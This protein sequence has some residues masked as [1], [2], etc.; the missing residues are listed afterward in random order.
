MARVFI[1]ASP[2]MDTIIVKYG[3]FPSPQRTDAP[4]VYN[5][6]VPA[7]R[8]EMTSSQS[9]IVTVNCKISVKLKKE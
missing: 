8:K 5:I 6:F 4:P 7:D 1:V 2:S 3:K 9:T